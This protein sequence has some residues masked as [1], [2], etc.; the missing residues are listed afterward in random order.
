MRPLRLLAALL[1]LALPAAPAAAFQQVIPVHGVALGDGPNGSTIVRT[2]AVTGMVSSQTRA[3]RIIPAMKLPPGTGVDAFLDRSREPWSLYDANVAGAFVPGLPDRGKVNG[4]DLGSTLPHTKLVDQQGH[5]VDLATDFRGKVVLLSFVFTRCPDKDECPTV[6]A[7]FAAMQKLLD[8]NRFQLIEISLDPVYDSPAVLQD[9]GK[10]FGAGPAWS[11]LT[12][13]PH[14]IVHLL[15]G[16][17]ISSLRVSDE[18]F[19]HNDKVFVTTPDSKVA[20][21][22][23]TLGFSPDGLAAQARHLNGMSSS[24]L[25]RW[26]LALVADVAALCGGS[27]FA[28]VVLLETLLFIFIA[29]VSFA[30]LFFVAR[31]IWRNA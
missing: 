9:Y 2:D 22:V 17:G 13:Q 11:L 1:A 20:D 15:N 16:F 8:P 5:L 21:I 23:Q 7:K 4:I 6:S 24:A 27:E 29:I 28:G 12:G 31:K 3:F 18:N 26:Q 10:Q 19:V 14:E 30:T 25:G